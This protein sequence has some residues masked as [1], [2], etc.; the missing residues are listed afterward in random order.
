MSRGRRESSHSVPWNCQRSRRHWRDTS[1]HGR[2]ST[3]R[4][5]LALP[6]YK[7]V[8]RVLRG[9]LALLVT[10][11][12]RCG[13]FV[14]FAEHLEVPL[15]ACDYTPLQKLQTLLCSLA[16]GCEWTVDIN[17]KLRPYPIVAEL[18]GMARFPD[19]SSVS[20]F[21]HHLGI[22]QRLQ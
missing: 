16:T 12:L 19:Q 4:S 10:F 9:A 20:R 6:F 14:P 7:P 13:F 5:K 3:S 18:L 2:N 22:A 8:V 17:H 15:K 21:L 1:R 11:A